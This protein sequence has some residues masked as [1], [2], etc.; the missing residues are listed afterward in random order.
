[1]QT[2]GASIHYIEEGRVEIICE[3]QQQLTQ[4]NGFLHAGVLTSICDSACGYA[5]LSVM[6]EEADV[7]SVE[8]KTNMLR[9]ANCKK[10]KAVGEVVKSG[11]TLVFCEGK[12]FNEDTGELLTT[13]QA[14]MI[15]IIR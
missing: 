3:H 4:Q 12:V 2:L 11:K 14:T 10:I 15:A 13:M 6:P 8:F 9:P 7:L 1:M 5:A